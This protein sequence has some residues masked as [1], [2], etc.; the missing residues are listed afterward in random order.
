MKKGANTDR[1]EL[2]TGS[3]KLLTGYEKLLA[4]DRNLFN[5]MNQCMASNPLRE[6]LLRR[7]RS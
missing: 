6:Q 7:T 4:L 5:R 1:S 3:Y 2:K